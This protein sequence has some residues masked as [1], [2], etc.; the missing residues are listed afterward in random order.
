MPTKILTYARISTM[1]IE[2][3]EEAID[4]IRGGYHPHDSRTQRMLIRL[5]TA[6]IDRLQKLVRAKNRDIAEL[7]IHHIK[8]GEH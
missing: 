7:M 8:K 1:T 4:Q 2:A 6:L 3:L 5:Q